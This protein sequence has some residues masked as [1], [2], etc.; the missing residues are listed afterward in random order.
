M[1][2]YGRSK[3]QC[4]EILRDY[5]KIHG[6]R[7]AMLRY[8]NVIGQDSGRELWEDHTPETHL[9]PNI[10]RALK[11]EQPFRLF[12]TDYPDSGQEAACVITSMFAIWPWSIW[13][14]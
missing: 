11:N 9:V 7:V 6:F 8:F 4:E 10:L 12:G 3:L 1:N 13:A 5:S 2:P 14:R